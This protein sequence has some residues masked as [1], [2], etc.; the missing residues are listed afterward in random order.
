MPARARERRAFGE[1]WLRDVRQAARQ[2]R[3]QPG[4]A[5]IA[6]LTL[7]VGIGASTAVFSVVNAALLRPLP[8]PDASSLVVL[9]ERR[10]ADPSA[11]GGVSY[12]NF[13]DLQHELRSFSTMAVAAPTSATIDAGATP[14]RLDG[15]IVSTDFFRALGVAP[16][17]GRLFDERDAPAQLVGRPLPVMLSFGTWQTHFGG[18]RDIAG[19]R[20]LADGERVEIIGV[21]PRD[22]FPVQGDPV[23]YW[24]TTPAMGDPADQSSA[25][26]SRN[27]RAYAGVLA[28]LR[29]GVTIEHARS[30]VEAVYASMAARTPALFT[31]RATTLMPLREVFV[32]DSRPTL[33]L[34]LGIVSLVVLVASVNVANM[35]VARAAARSREVAIRTAL[36]AG[37]GA[38]VRQFLVESLLLAACGGALAVVLSS[39]IVRTL[40]SLLPASLPRL[41]TLGPDWRVFGFI[42]LAIAASTLISGLV[43]AMTAARG[44]RRGSTLVSERQ[45]TMAI[46]RRVRDTL[47][48]A[49]VA[50]ALML[51]VGAGLLTNSLIRLQRVQPG[52]DV[53]R[54][55]TAALTLEG[56]RFDGP[57]TRPTALNQYLADVR[58]R[59]SAL[60]GVTSVAVAQAVPLTGL[61]NSTRFELIGAPAPGDVPSAQLRFVSDGYFET[62]GIPIRRGRAFTSTDGPDTPPVMVVNEAFVRQQVGAANPLGRTVRAGWGGN[63]PKTIVGVVGDVRHRGMGDT[64]RPEMYVPHTQFGNR[65]MVLVVRAA[66]TPDAVTADVIAAIRAFNPTLP[67]PQATS[68][69][70][71]RRE[72]LAL[73]RFGAAVLSGFAL[74]ALGL[75]LVGLY[76]VTSYGVVQRTREIGVRMA[77]GGQVADIW[78]LVI[79]EGLRPVAIGLV[80]GLLGSLATTRLLRA[81]VYEVGVADPL[82][83]VAVASL[84]AAVAGLA[85]AIPAR[86]AARVDPL[87]ALRDD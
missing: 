64:A 54:I 30:E 9:R 73:P 18:R 38:I 29:P 22:L 68:L 43:P 84:L 39:W 51:L 82:T 31:G 79:G 67:V 41:S 75:T 19:Q 4:Y 17:V 15:L 33:F 28:R 69:A 77:L 65:A 44:V 63:A 8:Y 36:G 37:R 12:L 24:T 50:L 32:A 55:L 3:R 81:W 66:T 34:L 72:T 71:Y 5:I 52:Y 16:V 74:L 20:L 70:G 13:V 60:P 48:A 83:Y 21:T 86:R 87:V 59:I 57:Q 61:E 78:R 40:S 53:D 26:G 10:S 2:A 25:N 11:S 23:A 85:C 47:L 27:F 7:G 49:E 45:A 46:P 42:L 14:V 1:G 56:P 6:V 76:G 35:L 80:A 62:L 58:A